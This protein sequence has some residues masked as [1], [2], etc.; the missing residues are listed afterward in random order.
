MAERFDEWAV[1]A[2]EP[3]PAAARDDA[4]P[5]AIRAEIRDTRE[6]LGDTLEALGE[7]LNPQHLTQHIRHDIRDATIG[8]VGHMARQAVDRV[9]ETRSTVAD[10]IREN[11]I[12]AALI[13][14][15]LGWLF[16]NRRRAAPR[17]HVYGPY[18]AYPP[19]R[20]D[21]YDTGA[22][23]AA[24]YGAGAYDTGAYD[25][26][27]YAAYDARSAAGSP[28]AG[29]ARGAVDRA[30]ERASEL[31]HDARER[32]GELAAHAQE[33]A[34]A[35]AD[36]TRRQVQR[37]ESRVEDRFHEQPLVV[38][39]ATLALGLAAGFAVPASDREVAL[40]GDARDRLVDRV[41]DAAGE[42]REKVQHVAS[43]VLD[44]AQHTVRDTAREAARDEGL[45]GSRG[46]QPP[47]QQPPQPGTQP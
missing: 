7:R 23:G 21:A 45:V 31:G 37:A 3:R 34:R 20:V 41:K 22:Y 35:A 43:R 2:R 47:Q 14:I 11:P 27:G 10:T 28:P 13:G 18:D 42:T 46:A 17:D 39:A 19:R 12:P 33:R 8:R 24:P 26:G 30:R 44:E 38:G 4:D 6:R 32:A 1:E 16:M 9:H 29:D 15:G 5:A 25:A 40:M 36:R